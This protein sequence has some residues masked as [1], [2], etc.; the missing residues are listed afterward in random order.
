MC[1]L[2]LSL[3]PPLSLSPFQVRWQEYDHKRVRTHAK[4]YI[5]HIYIYMHMPRHTHTHTHTHARTHAYTH[6]RTHANSQSHTNNAYLMPGWENPCDYVGGSDVIWKR[7]FLK[8]NR[9]PQMKMSMRWNITFLSPFL[10]HTDIQFTTANPPP[11]PPPHTH[12]CIHSAKCAS[13]FRHKIQIKNTSIK[14]P[15]PPPPSLYL[16]HTLA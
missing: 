3:S 1:T 15:P 6:T 2:S 13:Q 7:K 10:K 12:T 11:P 16:T 9:N 8:Q 14:H 5:I 4:I